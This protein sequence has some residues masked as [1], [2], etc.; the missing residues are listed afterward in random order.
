M[1]NAIRADNWL[2]VHGD[3]QSAQGREIKA[4]IRATFYPE[5]DDWKDM[6]I[7]RSVDVLQRTMR[8]LTD[9]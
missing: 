6:V 9:S 3:L 4:E 2:H 1:M 5:K 7:D 8:G